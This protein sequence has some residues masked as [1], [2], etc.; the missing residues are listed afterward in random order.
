MYV[1]LLRI[2]VVSEYVVT[3]RSLRK[4]PITLLQS[5]SFNLDPSYDTHSYCEG[6]TAP[7]HVISLIIL[8]NTLLRRVLRL[9]NRSFQSPVFESSERVK[10]FANDLR[11]GL[12]YDCND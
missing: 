6:V 9:W 1:A 2:S 11:T 7:Y 5:R 10:C 3:T 8:V 4:Q 12:L